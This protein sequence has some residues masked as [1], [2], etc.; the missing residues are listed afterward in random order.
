VVS[1]QAAPDN[2]PDQSDHRHLRVA[3][4]P[5]VTQHDATLPAGATPEH[6]AGRDRLKVFFL[7]NFPF[8]IGT[9]LKVAANARFY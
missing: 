7:H 9:I 2:R 4:S 5:P 1:R 6:P 8:G 3:C